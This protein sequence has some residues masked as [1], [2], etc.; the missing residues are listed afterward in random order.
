MQC[1]NCFH[2]YDESFGMCPECGYVEGESGEAYCLATGTVLQDRYVI[3]QCLGV[4]GFGITYKVFD[5]EMRVVKAVKEYFPSGLVARAKDNSNV[6]LVAKKREEEYLIGKQ[7]FLNEA[8]NMNKFRSHRNI[9]NVF[10]HFEANDTAYI[11]ME[12]LDGI[13][14]SQRIQKG[15]IP[16]LECVE[17]ATRICHAL[18][19]IHKEGVLHRDVSPDNIMLC[20][21]NTVKLFDFGA[22]RLSAK[23]SDDSH[24]TVIVKPG[25]A[26]PEQY[27]NV[28]QQD[29]RTDIYALGATMY[30]ALTGIKPMES[31]D[32]KVKDSMPTPQMLDAQIP[33]YL[34]NAILRAMSLD[35]QSRFASAEKLCEVLQ[36]EIV[37]TPPRP[38]RPKWASILIASVLVVTLIVAVIA[39]WSIKQEASKVPDGSIRLWYMSSGDTEKDL[40]TQK[41]WDDLITQFTQKHPNV[42]VTVSPILSSEYNQRLEEARKNG[43]MPHIYESTLL[44]TSML[45]DAMTLDSSL[46]SPKE[47]YLDALIVN[48]NQYPTGL[49]I[50]TIYIHKSVTIAPQTNTLEA[51]KA[52]C[53]DGGLLTNA[54]SASLY[55]SIYQKDLMDHI[56]NDAL[57]KFLAGECQIYLG[58]TADYLEIQKGL[59]G[60]YT[61][62]FP[63]TDSATYSFGRLWSCLDS[64]KN[65]DKISCALLDYMNSDLGQDLLNIR[66]FPSS[67][68]VPASKNG[69]DAYVDSY[70]ELSGLKDYLEN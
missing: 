47:L 49:L 25:F 14:L 54:S 6:L 19:A 37:V 23:S 57:D 34:N 13:T 35:P 11:V 4:G 5:T 70:T 42:S 59:A 15:P 24:M 29:A 63:D 67:G 36:E 53:K 18:T 16:Q 12:Y 46:L 41:A 48:E 9:I 17:I 68:C 22:A 3:G 8:Q 61:V 65:T 1:R 64:D 31:T 20:K 30:Y 10:S 66:N 2:E 69:I 28:N 62:S 52:A 58:T 43:T 7:R 56:S 27:E 50:P 51:L 32:R 44:P 26:P 21:D 40:A 33:T 60:M 39:V 38:P 55:Q 45:D